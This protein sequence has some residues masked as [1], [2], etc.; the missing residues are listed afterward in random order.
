M[1]PGAPGGNGRFRHADPAGGTG[2]PQSSAPGRHAA[3]GARVTGNHRSDKRPRIHIVDWEMEGFK[4]KGEMV[5]SWRCPGMFRRGDG[6]GLN[7]SPSEGSCRSGGM[8]RGRGIQGQIDTCWVR[9]SGWAAS[10]DNLAIN[11]YSDS[12]LSWTQKKAARN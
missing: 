8:G 4:Q 7:L 5:V 12:R 3:R 6:A 10:G 9:P 2:P 1:G 11:N